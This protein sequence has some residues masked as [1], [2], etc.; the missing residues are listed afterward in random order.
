MATPEREPITEY[1]VLMSGGGYHIRWDDPE[2]ERI[3]PTPKWAAHTIRTGGHVFRRR[4]IVVE[5]WEEM[6]AEDAALL[7]AKN[8]QEG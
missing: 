5:D 3:Y 6:S 1:G 8:E 7:G 4:V 2:I